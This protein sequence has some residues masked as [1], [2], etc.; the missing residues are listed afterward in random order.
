MV[1]EGTAGRRTGPVRAE[2]AL[3]TITT[4]PASPDRVRRLLEQVLVFA[5]ASLAALYTPGGDGDQL[6]LTESAGVPRSLYGLRESYPAD[7][8]SPAAEAHRTG[9]PVWLGPEQLAEG[10]EARRM[11]VRD[12]HLA[13]LPLPGRGGGWGAGPTSR[14]TTR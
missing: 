11:S 2:I 3:K 6:C 13:A 8:L 10:A 12:V 9:R 14:Q 4:D 1:S 7:G 5:G